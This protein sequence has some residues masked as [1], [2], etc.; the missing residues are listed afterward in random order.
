MKN[1]LA[2]I[3]FMIL[4]VASCSPTDSSNNTQPQAGNNDNVT[5]TQNP[6]NIDTSQPK[7]ISIPEI[8]EPPLIVQEECYYRKLTKENIEDGKKVGAVGKL[9][10]VVIEEGKR[11]EG[12]VCITYKEFQGS[13]PYNIPFVATILGGI[14]ELYVDNKKIT[15]NGEGEVFFRQ[16]IALE[17]GYNRVSVKAVGKSGESTDGYVEINI[18]DVPDKIEIK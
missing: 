17:H 15:I 3:C 13:S 18:Q 4:L 11:Y 7:K 6:D 16:K 8:I 14:T 10:R 9:V 2:V 12:K 1:N 5:A